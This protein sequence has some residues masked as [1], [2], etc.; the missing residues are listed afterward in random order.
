MDTHLEAST[1]Y[2]FVCA[3]KVVYVKSESEISTGDYAAVYFL[4]VAGI[5][6]VLS[7][8]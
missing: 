2:I 4:L 5:S 8:A 7:S 6:V 1:I 3:I